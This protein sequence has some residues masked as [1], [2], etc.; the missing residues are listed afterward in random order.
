MELFFFIILYLIP[1]I[2]AE[3]RKKK[4]SKAIAALNILFGITGIGWGAAL[5]W[6]LMED[7]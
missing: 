2:V 5:V 1:T 7:K 3:W 6:A 4:N